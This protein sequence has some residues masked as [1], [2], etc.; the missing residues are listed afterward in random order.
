MSRSSSAQW[1]CQRRV[2]IPRG[3]RHLKTGVKSVN[4]SQ[5]KTFVIWCVS[6]LATH[7]KSDTC[8]LKKENGKPKWTLACRRIRSIIG[9]RNGLFLSGCH[10]VHKFKVVQRDVHKLFIVEV[11]W[12]D[13]VLAGTSGLLDGLF[14]FLLLLLQLFFSCS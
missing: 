12:E 11:I 14:F 7:G 1:K 3:G 6:G 4:L 5:A 8:R 13:I 9:Y 2:A 10:A